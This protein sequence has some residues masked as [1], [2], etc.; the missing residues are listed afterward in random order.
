MEYWR[1]SGKYAYELYYYEQLINSG[2]IGNYIQTYY[3]KLLKL[4]EDFIH[5]IGSNNINDL[6]SF[7]KRFQKLAYEC[8]KS[9]IQLNLLIVLLENV[10]DFIIYQNRINQNYMTNLIHEDEDLIIYNEILKYEKQCINKLLCESDSVT[11]LIIQQLMQIIPIDTNIAINFI[12]KKKN[13]INRIRS[14]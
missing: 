4:Y 6:A 11:D 8:S 5:D 14:F 9:G 1:G 10:E 3:L 13:R 2:F 7:I 12:K